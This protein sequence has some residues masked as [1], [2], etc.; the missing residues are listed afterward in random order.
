MIAKLERVP[1]QKWAITPA[2]KKMGHIFILRKQDMK[3]LDPRIHRSKDID[4]I[5]SKK[6]AMEV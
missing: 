4:E 6:I 2:R 5:S 3:F 1:I